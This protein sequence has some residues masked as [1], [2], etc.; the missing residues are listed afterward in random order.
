MLL[1]EKRNTHQLRR[2]VKAVVMYKGK[3]IE[4]KILNLS[5]KGYH[6]LSHHELKNMKSSRCIVQL[7]DM[8]M[9]LK[10]TVAWK[11]QIKKQLQL[12]LSL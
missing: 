11:K 8:K 7:S 3:N 6:F 10:C 2:I 9:S 5:S 12:G 1:Q 4:G